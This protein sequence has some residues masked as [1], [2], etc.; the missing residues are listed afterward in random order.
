MGITIISK[1]KNRNKL[2]QC[3]TSHYMSYHGLLFR[4]VVCFIYLEMSLEDETVL[5]IEVEDDSCFLW[6]DLL[7]PW[8]MGSGGHG[9]LPYM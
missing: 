2:L 1:K 3:R 4:Y 8:H 5:C 6:S 7:A 9:R